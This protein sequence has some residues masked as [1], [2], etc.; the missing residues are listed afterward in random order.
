MT[1]CR[2]IHI[3]ALLSGTILTSPLAI[4]ALAAEGAAP[5]MA[6]VTDEIVVVARRREERLQDVPISIT[7]ISQDDLTRNNIQSIG[8]MQL[9]VPSMNMFGPFRNTPLVSI[10]GQGGFTPGGIPSVIIYLN[11]IPSPTS[12]QAGSPGGALGGNGLFYDL[13]SVQ[14]LKGPQGTLF[15]RNTTGGAV[16]LQSKR[17]GEELGA[18]IQLTA[19]NYKNREIDGA[20]NLPLITDKLLA[21]AAFNGQKREGFTKTLR[22]PN[23]PR[24]K[25]LDDEN[26]FS[27]RLSVTFRPSES[28]ENLIIADFI[29]SK[30]NGTS[31]ILRAV[32]PNP[33]AP[34]NTFFPGVAAQLTQQRALGIRNQVPLDV[35]MFSS[36]NRWGITDIL[37][38]NV[39]D[40]ITLRN[41]ASVSRTRYSQTIDGDGT[42]FPVFNPIRTQSVPYVT[43]QYTEELQA[44]GKSF[45]DVLDWTVGFFYLNQPEE[46]NF[47]RHTNSTLGGSRTIGFKQAEE[48]KA[49]FAQAETDLSAWVEG[50]GLTTGVRY[51]W[52]TI[53]RTNRDVRANGA[54]TSPFSD[55]NCVLSGK[56]SFGAPT[57]TVGLN[58]KVN[59]D[60]LLYVVS[61]RG[62]R[63]GGFNLVGDAQVSERSYDQERVTDVELGA[64]SDFSVGSVGF[65][66]SVALYRQF[67][68]DI[69][70][71]QVSVST[72]TGGPL[73]ITKN[74]GTAHITGAEVESRIAFD[75]NFELGG[76]FAW[77]DYKFKKLARPS[78]FRCLFRTFPSLS[79]ALMRPTICRSTRASVTCP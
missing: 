67:Y 66:N 10:R 33:A 14:V 5:A 69:Q 16:L 71:S 21:R 64:K 24:G 59:P 6:E 49:L 12:A 76:H 70:L 46:D 55:A 9:R 4:P 15:G 48:T 20:V 78:F 47:T 23:A 43:R 34:V 35:D 51:T 3:A 22:T 39:T 72:I 32:N 50:L 57:W 41:I 38:L 61:R 73:T 53:S 13:D 42:A 40:K 54:C 74:A 30:T 75:K 60:T 63:S 28:V 44:Q 77:I 8:D 7:A 26:H 36:Q 58:Y 18:R 68:S 2:H 19:G 11:E 62:F 29:N 31:A 37:S 65:S 25:D 79:S 52:E 56:K 27:G 45:D 1:I 17:P